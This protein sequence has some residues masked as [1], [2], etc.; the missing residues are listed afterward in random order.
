MVPCAGGA[1]RAALILNVDND[2]GVRGLRYDECV[3]RVEAD[4]HWTGDYYS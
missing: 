3:L 4:G 1:D 2:D